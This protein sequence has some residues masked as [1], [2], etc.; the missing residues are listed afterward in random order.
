LA[1]NLRPIGKV[2]GL[3]DGLRPPLR[4]HKVVQAACGQQS[5]ACA[6]TDIT[7]MIT[8]MITITITI[9]IMITITIMITIRIMIR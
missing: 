4:G 9:R 8:I 7:I 2:R 1:P 3:L 6:N 5:H